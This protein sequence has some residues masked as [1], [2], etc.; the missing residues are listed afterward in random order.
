MGIN[1]FLTLNFRL[2][3]PSN[4][5]THTHTIFKGLGDNTFPETM[6]SIH[7]VGFACEKIFIF[8]SIWS[9]HH[10]EGTGYS[11]SPG[12]KLG[13]W[14]PRAVVQRRQEYWSLFLR[15][16]LS[17]NSQKHRHFSESFV[18]AKH[19]DFNMHFV[20]VSLIS[21]WCWENARDT[22]LAPKFTT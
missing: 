12:R 1:I 9:T 14:R 20:N 16:Q 2:P 13:K 11:Y 7:P 18:C 5:H 3:P 22:I 21:P 10:W 19:L 15:Q 17:Q 8:L 6:D 4:I